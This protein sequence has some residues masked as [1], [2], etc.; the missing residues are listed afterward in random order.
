MTAGLRHTAHPFQFG[1][2]QI[3]R[4]GYLCPSIVNT[5][6]TLLQIIAV[7]AA[8]GI[9]S[10]VVQFQDHRAHAIQEET[11]VRHHQQRLVA[12]VQES[13]QPFYH[14]QIQVVR[15][16]IEYQ[17]VG[18]GYQHIRQCHALLLS[19]TQLAHRLVQVAN[20][21]LRQNL[22]GLQYLLRIALVIEARIEHALHGVKHRRLIQHA[23]LQVAAEDDLARVV[24]LLAR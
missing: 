23:H 13:L 1:A 4:T 14:L 19:A 21:Q 8:I 9:D 18:I 20:L 11:V 5:L 2:I 15:R 24:A 12:A 17:Q 6:L 3:I 10:P 16:L 22:L 7:V